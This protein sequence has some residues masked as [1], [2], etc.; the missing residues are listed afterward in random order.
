M[1][2][3]RGLPLCSDPRDA[4]SDPRDAMS[5]PRDAV[6]DPRDAMS[7]PCNAMSDLRDAMSDPRDAVSDP[8]DAMSDP[9]DAMSGSGNAVVPCSIGLPSA[10]P[11]RC[12]IKVSIEA[13][14]YTQYVSSLTIS[15]HSL[16][17][18][19]PPPSANTKAGVVHASS[20]F[21]L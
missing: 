20:D 8:R 10:S 16:V 1:R 12:S 11:D 21:S 4:M 3:Y 17:I 5:D 9:R 14:R 15:A 2:S 19:V 13:F 18:T 7:D 6:S